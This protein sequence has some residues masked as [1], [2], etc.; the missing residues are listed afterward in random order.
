MF[1]LFPVCA[2]A[3]ACFNYDFPGSS[4]SRAPAGSSA[5]PWKV[6]CTNRADHRLIA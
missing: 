6:K 4:V 1:L 2:E 3:V 5:L